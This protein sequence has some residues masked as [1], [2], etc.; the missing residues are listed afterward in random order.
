MI[1]GKNSDI[2]YYFPY[3]LEKAFWLGVGEKQQTAY[4]TYNSATI[5]DIFAVETTDLF[6]SHRAPSRY[7]PWI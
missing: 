2:I 5:E 7:N 4:L 1:Y 6:L 3:S